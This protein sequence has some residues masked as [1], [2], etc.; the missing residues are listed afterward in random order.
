MSG[1]IE[2]KTRQGKGYVWCFKC[3]RGFKTYGTIDTVC[4][5][6]NEDNLGKVYNYY[7]EW[8]LEINGEDDN[9]ISISP[10]WEQLKQLI[11]DIK[12]HEMLVDKYK[13]RKNDADRWM[14][15]ITQASKELQTEL[16]H[17]E[18]KNIPDIYKN[19]KRIK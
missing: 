12:L 18:E 1:K 11:K 14:D 13:D 16:W 15:T 19:Q 17:H 5:Y 10:S 2:L 3:N 6:C 4:P 9:K 8:Y 7:P